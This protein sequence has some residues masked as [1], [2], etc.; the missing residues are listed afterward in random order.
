MLVTEKS[1]D[2]FQA[3][4]QKECFHCHEPLVPPAVCWDGMP[5]MVSFHPRCV[6]SFCRRL[7]MDWEKSE[8]IA[9]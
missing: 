6:P 4:V 7:L 9:P 8:E 2:I 1:E 5:S 3:V